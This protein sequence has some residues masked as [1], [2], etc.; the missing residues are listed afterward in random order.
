MKLYQ[1]FLT[2]SRGKQIGI[3][4]CL[5]HL[6]AIFGLLGHHL[7]SR[8]LKP[9]RPMIVRTMAP[10]KAVPKME[11]RAASPTPVIAKP[12]TKKA[13]SAK[14]SKPA[15]VATKKAPNNPLMKEIAE[16]LGALGTEAK[17]SKPSLTLPSKIPQKAQIA[18]ESSADPTY[19]DFLI[20][21]LQNALDLPEYGEV[22]AKVEIDRFGR[23]I[24]CEIL[25][26][27][28]VKNAEFLKNQ[29]PNLTFPCLNDFGILDTTQTFTITF[30]N[31]EIR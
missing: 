13:T 12:T 22:R 5:I 21:Y 3:V 17:R 2:L 8:R 28:N 20:A 19:G 6:L 31:V 16:S 10:L 11:Y 14:P 18:P 24:D 15:P 4:V 26:A 1:Q 23:L 30:L 27:K 9:P 7:I 29:L 25:E